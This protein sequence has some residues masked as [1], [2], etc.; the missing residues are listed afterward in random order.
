MFSHY[1]GVL[2]NVLCEHR[3]PLRRGHKRRSKAIIGNSLLNIGNVWMLYS[4]IKINFPWQRRAPLQNVNRT[5]GYGI[6]IRFR[7]FNLQLKYGW[8]FLRLRYPLLL[9]SYNNVKHPPKFHLNSINLT[10]DSIRVTCF[11]STR[12]AK[13]LVSVREPT[14]IY[15]FSHFFDCE[16]DWAM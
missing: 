3:T 1:H 5:F 10:T 16:Q 4:L 12:V 2:S 15:C 11:L 7:V 13:L 8:N 6:E 14:V 9:N